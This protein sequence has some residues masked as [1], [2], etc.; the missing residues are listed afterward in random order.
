[1]SLS[2]RDQSEELFCGT[3]V[4]GR[5]II[6]CHVTKQKM[7][8]KEFYELLRE[9]MNL[10]YISTVYSHLAEPSGDLAKVLVKR[11]SR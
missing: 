7:K 6:N 1:M 8:I 9:K 5:S 11:I 4:K 3:Y 2:Y 10:C